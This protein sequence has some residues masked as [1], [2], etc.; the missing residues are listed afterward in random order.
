M[1]GWYN[2]KAVNAIDAKLALAGAGAGAKAFSSL[3]K[4]PLDMDDRDMKDRALVVKE[5]ESLIKKYVADQNLAGKKVSA[6]GKVAAASIGLKGREATAFA[7]MYDA[8][9]KEGNNIRNNSN[10]ASQRTH[11]QTLQANK[12][13]DAIVLQQE[14][15]KGVRKA[16]TQEETYDEDG[17]MTEK[18]VKRGYVPPVDF[19]IDDLDA[20]AKKAK[21]KS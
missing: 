14:K 21:K 15:A 18:K 3:A 9:I 4:I 10:N 16:P 7:R 13:N 17:K 5:N 1:A 12:H 19:T 6:S 2:D 20:V 8:D 11:A